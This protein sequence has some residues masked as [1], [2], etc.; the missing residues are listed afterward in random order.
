V[1]SATASPVLIPTFYVDPVVGEC[2]RLGPTVTGAAA[3]CACTK[4]VL[5]DN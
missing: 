1:V 4:A 2:V 3:G 5:Y